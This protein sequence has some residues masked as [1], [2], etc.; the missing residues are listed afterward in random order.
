MESFTI[1]TTEANELMK[2]LHDRMPVILEPQDYDSWLDDAVQEKD[3]LQP[4]LRPYLGDD[5]EAV[6]VNPIVN[7]VRNDVRECVERVG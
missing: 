3:D 2:P 6:P 4:L 1:I 7:N 5:L